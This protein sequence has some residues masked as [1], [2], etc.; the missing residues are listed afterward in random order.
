MKRNLLKLPTLLALALAACTGALPGAATPGSPDNS[1]PPPGGETSSYPIDQ[2]G[3]EA[4]EAQIT[5]NAPAPVFDA[6]TG[7]FTIKMLY[8][9]GESPVRGQT[10]FGTEMI[11]VPEIP[12]AYVPALDTTTAPGGQSDS[13]GV[14]VMSSLPPG[15]YAL[16]LMTP[17]GPIL[18][19]DQAT[20]ETIVFDI[21]ANQLT[22]FGVVIVLLNMEKL[23]P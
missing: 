2:P 23:E 10:F 14:L 1:Y 5:P 11:P 4:F 16:A 3:R 9:D 22:D 17:L 6:G 20:E 18:V 19:E 21:V 12:D 7:A 8:P 15:K 13:Q